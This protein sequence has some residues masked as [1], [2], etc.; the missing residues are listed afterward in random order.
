MSNVRRQ[1][2]TQSHFRV[3]LILS[4]VVG[5]AGGFLDLVIPSLI[6]ESFHAAQEVGDGTASMP[7]LL[8]SLAVAVPALLIYIASLFGLYQF[9]P[10]APRVAI[11]GT[12]LTLVV[13]PL[14]GAHTQSGLAQS[15][16]YLASYLWGAVLLLACTSTSSAWFAAHNGT[17]VA[18]GDA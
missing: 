11:V 1:T 3:L 18:E 14:V 9:R 6:P 4:L 17:G 13:F 7:Q 2:V 10:W 16:S 15:L 5:L 12:A 8:L